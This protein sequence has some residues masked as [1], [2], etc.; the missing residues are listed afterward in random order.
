MNKAPIKEQ[1]LEKVK[2][3]IASHDRFF[4]YSDDHRAYDK[5]KREREAILKF[6]TDVMEMPYKEAETFYI[7]AVK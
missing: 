1:Q 3:L 6:L 4:E 2:E 5:G 7:E